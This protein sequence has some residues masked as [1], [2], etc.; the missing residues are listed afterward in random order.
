VTGEQFGITVPTFDLKA[1]QRYEMLN[2]LL[3]SPN[4]DL[5]SLRRQLTTLWDDVVMPPLD[6]LSRDVFISAQVARSA[7]L[8]PH[9][10]DDDDE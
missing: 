2:H 7:E 3:P 1:P 8:L 5:A 9:D 10:I 4:T 6:A